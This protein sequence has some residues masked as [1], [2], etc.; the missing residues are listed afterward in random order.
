MLIPSNSDKGPTARGVAECTKELHQQ[1]RRIALGV[2]L[3]RA[4]DVA[5]E[6]EQR[7]L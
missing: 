7:S 6:T 2:R 5:S 4:H 3:D 1:S